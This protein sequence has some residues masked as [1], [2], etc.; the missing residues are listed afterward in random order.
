[1]VLTGRFASRSRCPE[2][3]S[4]FPHGGPVQLKWNTRLSPGEETIARVLKRHGYA[5]GM[6]GKWHLS[7]LEKLDEN[8]ENIDPSTPEGAAILEARYEE[9]CRNIRQSGGFDY[10][11]GVYNTNINALNVPRRLRFHNLEWQTR[12]AMDFVEQNKND[13][14]F[15]YWAT[16]II[17]SPNPMLSIEAD[18]RIT[19]KG[20]LKNAPGVS[21]KRK[22]LLDRLYELGTIDPRENG[23]GY[24]ET[25]YGSAGMTWLDDGIGALLEQLERLG[26]T[27]KTVIIIASDNGYQ[28]GKNSCYEAGT[29]VPCV[30]RWPGIVKAGIECSQLVS[31][32]DIAPTIFAACGVA[33]PGDMVLDGKSFLPLFTQPE[34]PIQNSLYHEIGYSRAVVTQDW[35]YL[36]IRFPEEITRR[37]TPDNREEFSHDGTRDVDHRFGA[38]VYYP[39]YFDYDQLYHISSDPAE[40]KNLAGNPLHTAKLRELKEELKKYSNRLPHSFGEFKERQIK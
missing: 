14:F 39:G 15:L 30:V 19:P 7:H 23:E 22:K 2:M 20:Y 10:A 24:W 4:D 32:V 13:P 37:G 35:K 5:T 25:M 6:V 36:A 33:P 31:N 1:S 11:D 18:P 12:K 9:D 29:N 3:E 8:R 40:Q 16:P 26:L 17:H 27:E 28:R 21:A 34:E 38:H